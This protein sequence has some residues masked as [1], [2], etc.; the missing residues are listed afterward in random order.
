MTLDTEESTTNS[1]R[2]VEDPCD[3][4]EDI[5]SLSWGAGGLC[6]WGRGD[7]GN[8]SPPVRVGG[9][10]PVGACLPEC[11]TQARRRF[12]ASLSISPVGSPLSVSFQDADLGQHD[13]LLARLQLERQRRRSRQS[14]SVSPAVSGS[15]SPVVS[16]GSP[17][18][19][20][21]MSYESAGGTLRPELFVPLEGVNW[22]TVGRNEP[23]PD[24][25][26]GFE[27]VPARRAAVPHSK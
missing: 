13:Y 12:F 14:A 1:W 8:T 9:G 27:A 2:Q 17:K 3:D 18:P 16:L 26:E 24:P 11:H 15:G 4:G 23:C 22:M 25:G 5:L 10:T 20:S 19:Q 7:G 21:S 6:G